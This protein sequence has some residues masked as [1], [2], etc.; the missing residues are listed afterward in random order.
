MNGG[1]GMRRTAPAGASGDRG[2]GSSPRCLSGPLRRASIERVVLAAGGVGEAVELAAGEV[3]EVAAQLDGPLVE[4]AAHAELDAAHEGPPESRRGAAAVREPEV[5]C[6]LLEVD[7]RPVGLGVEGVRHPPQE[8][9]DGRAEDGQPEPL[10]VVGAGIVADGVD[11]DVE[12]GLDGEV[13]VAGESRVGGHRCLRATGWRRGEEWRPPEV[14]ERTLV[15]FRCQRCRRRSG[16]LRRRLDTVPGSARRRRRPRQPRR[17]GQVL[18]RGS[19]AG[20]GAH[21]RRHQHRLRHPRLPRAPGRVDEEPRGREDG[22]D[23]ALR[24]RSRGPAPG[25]AA[26][27]STPG[28]GRPSP[29]TATGPWSASSGAGSSTRLIT[30]NVDGLHHAAGLRPG[31]DRR[32]PRHD[33]RGGVPRRAATGRRCEVVLDRVAG[34]RGGP[35]CRVC[36]GI[37]K[38]ATISFGQGL[39]AR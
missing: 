31:A 17:R 10:R 14:A 20:H 13:G 28:R 22:H 38:S 23:P 21:R 6:R 24:R 15:L 34:R 12:P 27:G 26:A 25:V 16:G 5:A 33:A 3:G 29:T 7:L 2:R 8:P 4:D 39:V 18:D 19:R 1:G 35:A 30:Q 32:D 9:Q 37:L 36:G 11:G